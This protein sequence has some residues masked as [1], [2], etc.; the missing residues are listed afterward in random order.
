MPKDRIASLPRNVF[1]AG[2]TSL[3]NDLSSEMVL[4]VMP[5]FFTSVLKSGAASLGVME[6]V[7]E[8]ASNLFKIISGR[9]S[10]KINKRK[11]FAVFGYAL[12]T[13]T[14]PFYAL[15]NTVAPVIGLRL[16]DRIGKGLLDELVD[17]IGFAHAGASFFSRDRKSVV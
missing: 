16:T 6:G 14:R 5:A 15:T 2:L 4:S 9:W 17:G 7:A 8:A 1:F 3:F 13:L 10:D 12:S 11:K